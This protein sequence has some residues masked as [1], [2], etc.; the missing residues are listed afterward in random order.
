[1]NRPRTQC[2]SD[3]IRS[4]YKSHCHY[5]PQK[6]S[7]S[8]IN[9]AQDLWLDLLSILNPP[10][11]CG[12][13]QPFHLSG[14][15]RE[16][17]VGEPYRPGAERWTQTGRGRTRRQ[18]CRGLPPCR[19]RAGKTN[20]AGATGHERRGNDLIG[21]RGHR[22]GAAGAGGRKNSPARRWPT[23]RPT[24]ATVPQ[25]GHPSTVSSLRSGAIAFATSAH[26][27]WAIP[28]RRP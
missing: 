2:A 3:C 20:S 27:G 24:S 26:V 15:L 28:S 19:R 23:G 18:G 11:I 4:A 21:A 16:M 1:M 13:G 5:A 7:D 6:T 17:A 9:L 22:L 8:G 10:S 12:D 14:R 25:R